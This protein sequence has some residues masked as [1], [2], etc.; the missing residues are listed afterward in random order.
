MYGEI[1]AGGMATIHLGRLLGPVGFSRTVAVKRLHAQYAKDPDFVA[2]F[3]DEAR[4]AARIQNPNVVQTMDVV[5]EGDALFL[6]MEYIQGETF[7][8]LWRVAQQE[9]TP[10]ALSIISAV[11]GGT[12]HGLHA[13]HEATDEH[14]VPLGVVHRDVSPQ[15]VI[16]GV[17]GTPRILDFGV[18]KA[19][20]KLQHTRDGQLKGKLA[21]MAPEQLTGAPVARSSDIYAAA[22]VLWEAVTGTRL[23]DGDNDARVFARVLEGNPAPPSHLVPNL[24]M[25]LEDVVMRGLDRDPAKRF[26]TARDMALALE[27]A[28]RSAPATEVGAWVA[29]GAEAAL[30]KRAAQVHELESSS[31]IKVPPVVRS[32]ATQLDASQLESPS[33]TP[34]AF[35]PPF[36]GQMGSITEA[37]DLGGSDDD[38]VPT[39]Y[40]QAYDPSRSML[41]HAAP[42]P[43]SVPEPMSASWVPPQPAQYVGQGNPQY[44]SAPSQPQPTA[45][46]HPAATGQYPASSGQY[47][48]TGSSPQYP[49]SSDSVSGAHSRPMV[50][51]AYDPHASIQYNPSA[52]VHIVEAPQTSTGMKVLIALMTITL[53]FVLFAV[54]MVL[55]GNAIRA[56]ASPSSTQGAVPST[57]QGTAGDPNVY[58]PLSPQPTTPP[59]IPE[60]ALVAP[61]ATATTRFDN[62]INPS[63][64]VTSA[65]AASASAAASAASA[66]AKRAKPPASTQATQKPQHLP[67]QRPAPNC[68][69]PFTRDANGV[70]IYK[71][72]CL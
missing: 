14:G 43:Q 34:Q 2:M 18:A 13:V 38:D 16:V 66:V 61:T 19:A 52:S 68:D 50:A 3:L 46:Q 25:Q 56:A 59:L 71:P 42:P 72:E 8:K 49:G 32:H 70:K 53:V 4:L 5:S 22:V 55:R 37:V 51:T 62:A 57:P 24:P 63:G 64:A 26:A 60:G 30:A 12:L 11:I 65:T 40:M 21:Y 33:T 69:P 9:G 39:E 27:A 35:Q 58:Q 23:Y 47:P 6:V 44:S 20:G 54:F 7:A 29:R 45:V 28:V 67:T 15:N 36:R 48:A 31:A 17:D 10:I 1:A 41:L